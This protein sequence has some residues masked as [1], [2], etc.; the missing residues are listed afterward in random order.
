MSSLKPIKLKAVT[1]RNRGLL[2]QDKNQAKKTE[3]VEKVEKK[4]EPKQ[5]KSTASFR[6]G[7]NATE[8]QEDTKKVTSS[9]QV[10]NVQV[11]REPTA[12]NITTKPV[13]EEER[14][15]KNQKNSLEAK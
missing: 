5:K 8:R 4:E 6:A 12:K 7:G 15:A 10:A 13:T 1:T 14:D 9:S 2:V 3:K 11:I